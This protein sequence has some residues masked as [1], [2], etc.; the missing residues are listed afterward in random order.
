V[1]S[2]GAGAVAVAVA[3][4][5]A[6]AVLVPESEPGRPGRTVCHILAAPTPQR[7]PPIYLPNYIPL[8]FLGASQPASI[9]CT[10][11]HSS[12]YFVLSSLPLD[13]SLCVPLSAVIAFDCL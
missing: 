13:G 8:V 7:N 12:V 9:G 1:Y 4:A 5:V 6:G 11:C 3:V 2:S 10:A